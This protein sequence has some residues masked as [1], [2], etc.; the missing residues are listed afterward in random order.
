MKQGI[1]PP[2]LGSMVE[3]GQ[4]LRELF[5]IKPGQAPVQVSQ[6]EAPVSSSAAL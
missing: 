6:R 3:I 5:E 2:Q 4:G 1:L